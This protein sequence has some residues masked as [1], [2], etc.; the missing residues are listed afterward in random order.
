[1]RRKI[2]RIGGWWEQAE[3]STPGKYMP[4]GHSRWEEV[5]VWIYTKQR[6]R[7]VSGIKERNR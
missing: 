6:L 1:M 3:S 7:C 4:G 2:P 5:L